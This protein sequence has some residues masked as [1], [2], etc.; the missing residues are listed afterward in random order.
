MVDPPP[1][2]YIYAICLSAGSKQDIAESM[3]ICMRDSS[4]QL[5]Y[6]RHPS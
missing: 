5:D 1:M 3:T 6:E 2:N 4:K